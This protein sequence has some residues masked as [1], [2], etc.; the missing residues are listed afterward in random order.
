MWIT[1][2]LTHWGVDLAGLEGLGGLEGENQHQ[3]NVKNRPHWR[4]PDSDAYSRRPSTGVHVRSGGGRHRHSTRIQGLT[5]FQRERNESMVKSNPKPSGLSTTDVSYPRPNAS[6]TPPMPQ[7]A[8]PPAARTLLVRTLYEAHHL[9]LTAFLT[10]LVGPDRASDV[11]Q[12]VFFS[13]LRVD[14]LERRDIT[15][16]YLYRVGENLVR[17]GYHRDRRFREVL[18]DL[19]S[20]TTDEEDRDSK[21]VRGAVQTVCIRAESLGAAMGT[22]TNKEQSAIKLIV[23]R[24]LSHQQ[25]AHSLGV[26]VTTITNWKH[27]GV[28][29]LKEH[30]QIDQRLS[31]ERSAA[32]DGGSRRSRSHG[33]GNGQQGENPRPPQRAGKSIRRPDLD[34]TRPI[35]GRVG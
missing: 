33:R 19:R 35:L 25:A 14:N 21:G 26:S 20:T 10:R 29:K 2:L 12:E 1:I 6:D 22:L 18:E 32:S 17:K 9:K 7:R 28:K 24:G 5:A 4:G 27:R 8:S 16:S 3:F 30:L 23:C 15:V 13:L 34:A 31:A 11:M